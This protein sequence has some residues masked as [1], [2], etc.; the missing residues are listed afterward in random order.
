MTNE[1][2]YKPPFTE[3]LYHKVTS[4]RIAGIFRGRKLSRIGGKRDFTEKTFVD[5]SLIGTKQQN[6][7][8]FSLLKVSR[9]TVANSGETNMLT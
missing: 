4:Y 9:Y 5:C 3:L 8:N 7:Q 1:Q 2:R 6:S